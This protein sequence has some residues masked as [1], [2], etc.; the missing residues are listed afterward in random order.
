MLRSFDLPSPFVPLATSPR[1]GAQPVI[2]RFVSALALVLLLSD[3]GGSP[4]SG[5]G[6]AATPNDELARIFEEDQSA[7]SGPIDA[8]D[9]NALNAQDSLRRQRVRVVVAAGA[10]KSAADFYHAAMVFQHGRDSLA[11]KQANEWAKRSEALDSSNADARWLVAATWDRYQ[12]SRDEPQWYGTQT[13]RKPRGT[14]PVVLYTIDTTRITDAERA[15]RGVGT[16]AELRAR[17]DTMNRRLGLMS[18]SAES[19]RDS[20]LPLKK[21]AAVQEGGSSVSTP[22]RGSAQRTAILA[23][24]REHLKTSAKFRVDHI[25]VAGRW[26]FVRA[27]EVVALDGGELQETDFTVAALLQLP[28]ASEPSSW[29]VVDYWTLPGE[30]EQPLAAFTRRLHVL[31]RTERLPAALFPDDM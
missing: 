3:C 17:L 19:R 1:S 20:E 8:M 29:R 6:A 9:M 15:R 31:Q 5:R 2:A 12:M 7:R 28:A 18:P 24:I 16:L 11:Y 4:K 30:Q 27:T 21:A 23:A 22:G 14:G 25:R 13:D 26:A 10:L